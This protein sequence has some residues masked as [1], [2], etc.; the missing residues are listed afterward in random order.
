M[1]S[2]IFGLIFII[3]SIMLQ[4]CGNNA[5]KEES[6]ND[7]NGN[8]TTIIKEKNTMEQDSTARFSYDNLP[9][10]PIFQIHT[11]EGTIVVLLYKDTPLHRDNFIKLA[12]EKFYDNILFHRIIYG[13]MIQTGDPL[14]KDSTNVNM[15]GT[16]GPGYTIPAEILPQYTHKKGA[17]AAARQGDISNPKRES[18]GS[19]FYIVHNPEHCQ[20]LD[21]AYTIFGETIGGFE[22]IDKIAAI[23]TNRYDQ[24]IKDVRIIS[25]NPIN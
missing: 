1:K 5:T 17:L 16:G 6:K 11:T 4:S 12:S 15:F 10:E 2:K 13:F 3:T 18:S 21:G 8:D 14:T 23:R 19:Q 7:T 9:D 22:V 25:I 24:P 20:H